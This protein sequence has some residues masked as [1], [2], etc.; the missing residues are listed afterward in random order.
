MVPELTNEY[1]PR[2]Y[3]TLKKMISQ[4]QQV[5]EKIIIQEI[6]QLNDKDQ[7]ENLTQ[8][9]SQIT[10]QNKQMKKEDIDI[11]EGGTQGATFR[12]LEYL[13]QT[14]NSEDIVNQEDRFKFVEDLTGLDI[15]NH[16]TIGI[17]LSCTIRTVVYVGPQIRLIRTTI[18]LLG[19]H[20]VLVEPP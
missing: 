6:N 19:P 3:S 13:S 7:T 14:N 1:T 20:V 10:S 4:D 18:F 2:S 11:N 15:V 17:I 9:F 12:I 5:K 16:L 8:H